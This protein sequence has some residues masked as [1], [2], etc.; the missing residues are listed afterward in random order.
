MAEAV[1]PRCAPRLRRRAFSCRRKNQS[2]LYAFIRF[3][4]Q[5]RF[6]ARRAPTDSCSDQRSTG[7]FWGKAP[8]QCP[9]EGFTP[10]KSNQI[11]GSQFKTAPSPRRGPQS[12]TG[13]KEV[14]FPCSRD[15]RESAADQAL[16][17]VSRILSPRSRKNGTQV[18]RPNSKVL[19][20]VRC[21]T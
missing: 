14:D 4:W 8:C 2:L 6:A 20:A 18:G 7:F 11:T 15:V 5:H 21:T 3:A 12:T 13:R 16:E 17:M 1:N 10:V 9:S 19:V